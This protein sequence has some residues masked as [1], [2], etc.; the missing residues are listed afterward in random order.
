MTR[1]ASRNSRSSGLEVC[2]GPSVRAQ[3]DCRERLIDTTL[4]LCIS[5]GYEATTIDQIA[6]AAKI[7]PP[8]FAEHFAT[9]D[10]A[11]MSVVDDLVQ[12]TAAAL[13]HVDAA[14]GPEQA[15]LLATTEVVTAIVD[16]HGVITRDRMLAMAHVVTAQPKLRK[17]ASSTRRRVLTKALAARLGVAVDN[18][19]VRQATTMWSAIAGGAYLARHSMAD[20]YDPA[21]DA[22]LLERVIS[23][24]GASFIEVMG[25][26]PSKPD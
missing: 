5:G 2:Y 7:T 10:A 13:G 26:D 1:P 11:I 4:A 8:E 16:G 17:Q 20:H 22:Q 18:R 19:R 25:D 23:E 21:Q 14:A 9:K 3:K 6:A 24:L 15:V 12:A